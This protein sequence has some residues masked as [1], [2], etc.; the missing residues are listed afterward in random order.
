M[1]LDVCMCARAA[2]ALELEVSLSCSPPAR[3]AT[4]VYFTVTSSVKVAAK[5][6][7]C[8]LSSPLLSSLPQSAFLRPPASVRPLRPS[9]LLPFPLSV[10]RLVFPSTAM[11]TAILLIVSW[12]YLSRSERGTNE[13]RAVA[14]GRDPAVLDVFF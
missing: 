6:P 1:C 14:V 2:R 3:R 10:P 5:Y 4:A 7:N 11:T 12:S 13:R 8:C 9:L